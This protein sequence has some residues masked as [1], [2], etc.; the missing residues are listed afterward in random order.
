MSGNAPSNSERVFTRSESAGPSGTLLIAG[1]VG[2]LCLAG[3][4]FAL[5]I[6]GRVGPLSLQAMTTVPTLIGIGAL[7]AGWTLLRAPCRVSVDRDGLTIKT[8]NGARQ[9]Y[10]NEVGCAVAGKGAM[11]HRR[12][13]NITDLTGKSIVKLDESFGEFDEMVAAISSHVAAKRDDTSIGILRKKARRQGAM[14][15]VFG[16][17]MASACLFMV[18][19]T[20]ADHRAARLLQEKGQPGEA[21]IV[22]RFV[23]PN[24]VTKRLEYSVVGPNGPSGVRNVE[25]DPAYWDSLAGA[26]SVDVIVVPGE[27]GISRLQEGEVTAK[28]FT[29]TPAGGYG[30]AAIGGLIA[31]FMLGASPL[32]WNG[33]DL[34]HDA[35]TRKWSLKRYGKVLWS[36]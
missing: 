29:N 21:K 16:L 32:I 3:V 8:R 22:R 23:A 17:L 18:S 14:A 9:Y 26:K 27:P 30:L 11:S 6:Y 19:K 28:D 24:G 15:F 2:G 4:G 33:W 20:R 5:A 25:V 1:G 34:A 36:T 31:L 13:L 12:L 35:K 10:W 7:T